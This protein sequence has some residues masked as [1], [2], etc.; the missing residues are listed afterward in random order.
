[1]KLLK[2][3]LIDYKNLVNNSSYWSIYIYVYKANGSLTGKEQLSFIEDSQE[4]YHMEV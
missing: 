1:M 2:I 4:N 3:T